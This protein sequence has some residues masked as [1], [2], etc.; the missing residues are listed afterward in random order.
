MKKEN[1]KTTQKN[2]LK[3]TFSENNLLNIV[4]SKANKIFYR[5]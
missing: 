1:N 2:C 5:E 3:P 4:K